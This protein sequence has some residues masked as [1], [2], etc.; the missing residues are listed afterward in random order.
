MSAVFIVSVVAGV[1]TLMAAPD[2]MPPVLTTGYDTSAFLVPPSEAAS[3]QALLDRHGSVRLLPGDY[4]PNCTTSRL[5]GKP[6]S[7]SCSFPPANLTVRTGQRVWGLPGATVPGVVVEPGAEG[8]V[9]SALTFV[10][11]T[12]LF[13][14]GTGTTRRSTFHRLNG[15]HIM[16]AAGSNVSDLL[17]VGMTELACGFACGGRPTWHTTAFTVGGIHAEA[18]SS[19]ANCKFIR[20]MVHAPWPLLT[21]RTTEWVGNTFLWTNV[22]GSL[23]SSFSATGAAELTIVGPDMETYGACWIKPAIEAQEVGSVRL[24]GPHG[25]LECHPENSTL[26]PPTAVMVLDA[27]RVWITNPMSLPVW[28][29]AVANADIV[30]GRSVQNYVRIDRDLDAPWKTQ[31]AV[32]VAAPP[33]RLQLSSNNTVT[34]GKDGWNSV[35]GLPPAAQAAL[36][37]MV[38]SPAGGHA[39]AVAPKPSPLPPLPPSSAAVAAVTATPGQGHDDSDTLQAM[40][41]SWVTSPDSPQIV[42]AGTYYISK[43]LR[44]GRLP[45]PDGNT[46]ACL[47]RERVRM[48]IGTGEDSVFILAK[49]PAM[50]MVTSDGC[51]GTGSVQSSRFHVSGLTLAGGAVGLHMSA[52]TGALQ[53]TESMIS[54]VRFRELSKYGIWLDDIFGL[55]NNLLS[56]LSFDRC[57]VAFYQRAPDSQRVAPSGFCKPPWHNPSLG[58][59]DK[60]VFYRVQV[61]N[62][63]AGYELDACRADNLNYWVENFVSNIS[64]SGWD[65]HSNSEAAIVSSHVENVGEMNGCDPSVREPGSSGITVLNSRMIAGINTKYML[66]NSA[67]VEGS[68]FELG[69]GASAN[70]SLF[71]SPYSAPA[72]GPHAGGSSADS[73]PSIFMSRTRVSAGLPMPK[74]LRESV[75]FNNR[76]ADLHDQNLNKAAL[77]VNG[78]VTTTLADSPSEIAPSSALCFGP[79]W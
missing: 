6:P 51:G 18:G 24:F 50:I 9:L 57:G 20:S 59:M 72:R 44:V 27:K 48:L 39:W 35:G 21:V 63:R 46:T 2:A 68:S 47:A 56:F 78:S 34:L 36:K 16:F 31:Q 30:L 13:P 37:Q 10:G 28:R 5:P 66:A 38:A 64:G 75:L 11:G 26:P 71:R 40:I 67:E 52:A 55:D 61:T 29:P 15:P 74:Q 73:W 22:L 3:L 32:G 8:V 79:M 7:T 43:T 19:V 60:I 62:C 53:I 76:F 17:F 23:Q 49:D 65:L 54:H 1:A 12:L 14:P 4:R 45:D 25:R 70:A 77:M 42:P 58:Y 41:D 33:F 69:D